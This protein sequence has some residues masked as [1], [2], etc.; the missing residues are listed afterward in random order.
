M[1]QEE[2]EEEGWQERVLASGLAHLAHPHDIGRVTQLPGGGLP[3]GTARAVAETVL[4]SDLIREMCASSGGRLAVGLREEGMA[5]T[6]APDAETPFV[7]PVTLRGRPEMLVD[8]RGLRPQGPPQPHA[9]FVNALIGAEGVRALRTGVATTVAVARCPLCRDIVYFP[10]ALPER[11]DCQALDAA[12]RRAHAAHPSAG[13]PPQ[14]LGCATGACL[15]RYVALCLAN[16]HDARALCPLMH[17]RRLLEEE[18][19]GALD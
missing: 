15:K 7:V 19:G 3:E 1:E 9:P 2:Q 11:H 17:C 4:H 6:Y 13:P 18:E 14:A 10:D 8:M 5:V 12:L 16:R